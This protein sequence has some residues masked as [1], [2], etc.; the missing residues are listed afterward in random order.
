[1]LNNFY[2]PKKLILKSFRKSSVLRDLKGLKNGAR[3]QI[4]AL[5]S[6]ISVS[7]PSLHLTGNEYDLVKLHYM[8][9]QQIH[10]YYQVIA[11]LESYSFSTTND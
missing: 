7:H 4:I 1:M 6:L 8:F 10:L 9:S 5:I 3:A 11:Y 2:S